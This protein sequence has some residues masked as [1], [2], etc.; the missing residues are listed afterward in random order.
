MVNMPKPLFRERMRRCF[1][2]IKHERCLSQRAAARGFPLRRLRNNLI[3]ASCLEV[4]TQPAGCKVGSYTDLRGVETPQWIKKVIRNPIWDRAPDGAFYKSRK[5]CGLVTE[6][7]TREL[8][9]RT[10]HLFERLVI[11]IWRISKFNFDALVR[12]IR[13]EMAHSTELEYFQKTSPE[14]LER[15]EALTSNPLP[16]KSRKRR[17]PRRHCRHDPDNLAMRVS[18]NFE[19][20]IRSL[21]CTKCKGPTCVGKWFTP[22]V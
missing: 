1:A 10:V 22:R 12:A 21:Y 4:I 3:K 8:S 2:E 17:T 18:K 15:S 11:N 20:V 9:S 19:L 16:K 5:I 13:A 7:V 14:A 6:M